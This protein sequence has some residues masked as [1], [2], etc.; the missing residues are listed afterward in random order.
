MNGIL[1][2]CLADLERR[3]DEDQEAANRAA[4]AA[5]INGQ[6]C[7]DV[8]VAP[9]RRPAPPLVSWPRVTANEAIRDPELMLLQQF[10]RCSDLLAQGSGLRLD[11]RCNY[12]TCLIPSLFGAELF[13]MDDALDTLPTNHPLPVEALERVARDGVPDLRGGLGG[14]VFDTAARFLEVMDRHP[15]LRR[16][17]EIYHPDTQGPMDLTELL[18]GSGVFVAF[19]DQPDMV[20]AILAVVTQTMAAFLRQWYRQVPS[21]TGLR[22]HWGLAHTGG[23]VLRSDSLVN[24]SEAFYREFVQAHDQW[25][26]DQFDGGVVHFCGRGDHVIGAIGELR[27]LHAVNMTQPELND[28]SVIYRHTVERWILLIGVDRT[29]CRVLPPGRGRVHVF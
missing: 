12:G 14:Q 3:L 26:L 23:I 11:V 29:K 27:G 8:F 18:W 6:C 5:F 1:E 13:F 17:I 22:S 24:I 9:A 25:L 10:R 4:W 15:V 16:N 28:L 20:H 19:Y 7:T 21:T 2:Q